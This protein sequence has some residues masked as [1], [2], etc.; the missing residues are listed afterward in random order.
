MLLGLAS[1]E[2]GD[3]ATASGL[4]AG[5]YEFAADGDSAVELAGAVG[6]VCVAD[7]WVTSS[8]LEEASSDEEVAPFSTGAAAASLASAVEG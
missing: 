8:A 4:A 6:L 1:R 2:V 5:F 3:P 7:G